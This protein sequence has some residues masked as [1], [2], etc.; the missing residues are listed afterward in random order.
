[1]P[2]QNQSV[3]TDAN[4][5]GERSQEYAEQ[6]WGGHTGRLLLSLSLAW[7]TLQTG[8]FLLSPLLPTIISDLGLTEATAGVALGMLQLMYAATQF[9]SGR[10]SDRCD[11]P[12]MVVGGIAVLIVA[13]VLFVGATSPAVFLLSVVTLGVGKGLFAVPSRAQLSDLFVEKRGQA[14]GV[15]SAGTDVGG[16]LASVIGVIVTGGTIL[17]L[18]W[19]TISVSWRVAFVPVIVALVFVAG[20]YVA[21]NREPYQVGL[22]QSGLFSTLRRLATTSAQR[23]ALLAFSLFSF[24]VGAW[25]NFLP[26]YLVATKGFSEATA[27]GVFAVGFIVGFFAKPAAGRVADRTQRRSV[28][29]AGLLIAAAGLGGVVVAQQLPVVIAAIAVYSLGYKAVFPVVDVL[30]LDAAPDATVGGDLGAA[31][32]VFLGVGAVGPVYLGWTV[33]TVGYRAG[34]LGLG[35]S[36]LVAAVVLA[37][38]L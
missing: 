29:V 27:A 26:A 30:L 33:D 10:I 21:W 14:L 15:Y 5:A 13:F 8:R 4:T 32:A 1:M 31:R 25:V 23:E 37:R 3:T 20:A 16:L 9:P 28:A 18:Q 19:L 22:P 34:F 12:A 35:V 36:L 6:L 38:G 2:R 24:V 17:G 7:A 11:R